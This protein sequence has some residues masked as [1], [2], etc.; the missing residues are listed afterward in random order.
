MRLYVEIEKEVDGR[1]LAGILGL[2]GVMVYAKSRQEVL[3]RVQAL[4][5]QVPAEQLGGTGA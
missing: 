1:W 5:L 2:P 4:A 3:R